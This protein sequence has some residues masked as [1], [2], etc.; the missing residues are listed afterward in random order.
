MYLHPEPAQTRLYCLESHC[1]RHVGNVLP[2]GTPRVFTAFTLLIASEDPKPSLLPA[3]AVAKACWEH[4][5]AAAWLYGT[6]MPGHC[7][8]ELPIARQEEPVLGSTA[9][10]RLARP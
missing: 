3:L 8:P 4:S 2:S 1:P 5:R 7:E 10:T 9:P 6:H